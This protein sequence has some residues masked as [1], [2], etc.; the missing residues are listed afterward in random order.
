MG[1]VVMGEE[2][3]QVGEYSISIEIFVA[4][5]VGSCYNRA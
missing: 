2:V 5:M 1:Q 4:A 3:G